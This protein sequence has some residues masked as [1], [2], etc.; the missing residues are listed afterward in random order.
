MAEAEKLLNDGKYA[1]AAA[2]VRK[3]LE[4]DPRSGPLNEALRIIERQRE[5]RG[6]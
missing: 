4:I 3:A 2:R 6:K 1:E 5:K